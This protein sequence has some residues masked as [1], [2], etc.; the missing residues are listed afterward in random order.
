MFTSN[1]LAIVATLATFL[2]VAMVVMVLGQVLSGRDR[3]DRIRAV[4]GSALGAQGRSA[5]ERKQKPAPAFVSALSKLSVPQG[6]WQESDLKMKFIRA[7]IREAGAPSLYFTIKTALFAAL[8]LVFGA[9]ALVLAPNSSLLNI[10]L[11]ALI[12]AALGYY[13][14]DV[15]LAMRT[16]RR[17]TEMQQGLPDMLDLLV[18]CIE[19]GLG[20]D[21]AMN[22]I[23]RELARTSPALAEEFYLAALEIRAGAGRLLALK[24]MALRVHLEDFYSLVAMLVQS[25][26]FGTSLGDA[27]RVQAEAIRLRRTQR[28]EELAAKIPVKMLFPLIFFI[29]PSMMIVIL[30]PALMSLSGVFGR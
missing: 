17:S 28:A 12:G 27:L 25:D 8:L 23:S 19:S 14:P 16:Q 2:A 18:I 6:G 20:V 7:G 4:L 29:F 22:R 11:I 10:G 9:L 1:L 21:A 26:K 30:G 3:G 13:L 5:V 15:Y 24:N